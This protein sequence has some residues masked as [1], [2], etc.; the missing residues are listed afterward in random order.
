MKEHVIIVGAGMAGL[1]AARTLAEEGIRVTLVEA[2]N[3]IGGR[4]LTH[5]VGG[6]PI[7]LGAEF[8]HGRPPEL[9]D[10]IDEAGL[11]T[12]ERGGAQACFEEETLKRCNREENIF[13]VLED[14]E[15]PPH[16]D[17]SFAEYLSTLNISASQRTSLLSFVEGFNAADAR[18]ISTASLGAQQMAEEDEQGDR[19]FYLSRG[20]DRIV[21]YLASRIVDHGGSIR[22]NSPVRQIQWSP[23][24]VKVI[25]DKQTFSS[26]R[27]IITVPLGVLQ[28]RTLPI[29]PQPEA[30]L[31]AASQL[32]MGQA[33]RF[34]LLFREPFWT[35]LPASNPIED[36]NFLFSF[37]ELP[38]VWWTTHP[39]PS[40]LLTG[41]VGGPR[42]TSLSGLNSD[43]LAE[44]ACSALARIFSLEKAKLRELL[45]ACHHHDWG[46][47]PFSLGAYS[48][49]AKG[50]IDASEQLSQPV[51]N[52]LFF[53]GEH[54]DTTGNWG[55]V[56]AAM[57]SGLRAAQ[58]ILDLA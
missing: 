51:E 42:S 49:V 46:R 5:H 25:D 40:P 47:D 23:S 58:Q 4:I 15:D 19:A 37:G 39:H 45:I 9:W 27:A 32:R 7:E 56:H 50:G 35:K 52:T 48:Y 36:L 44:R 28:A 2:R 31:H 1:S 22:L 12:Y 8:I 34:S 43:E 18:E 30:I 6:Q 3:H 24:S 17:L 41:W 33:T 53:A 57:R 11:E 38:P 20:Y 10:L 55:T 16:P 14:L 13:Q 26:R 21:Q 29:E 54:T